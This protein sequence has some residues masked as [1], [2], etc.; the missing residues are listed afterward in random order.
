MKEKTPGEMVEWA[1]S[2]AG[3]EG[4]NPQSR[5][6]LEA[7]ARE[8]G[9]WSEKMHLVGR[10][11]LAGNLELLVLDSLLLLRAAEGGGLLVGKIADIGS[12]AGFPG[13]VWSIARPELDVTFFE[14]RL[15]PQLFLERVVARLGLDRAR[16]IGDDASRFREPAS[17]D[18]AVSK[19]AGRLAVILPIADLLLRPEGVYI[20]IKGRAWRSEVPGRRRTAMRLQSAVELG[21]KRGTAII[22][23]KRQIL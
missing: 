10:G 1:I 9:S 6:R 2:A 22:F 4:L 12:G 20:T 19:A 17:F 16:V 14:R 11:R 15:K 18:V 13:V 8:V 5:E 23:R 7:Y 3:F 21:G